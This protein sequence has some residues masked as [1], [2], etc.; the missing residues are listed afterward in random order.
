MSGLGLSLPA[1]GAGSAYFLI[2]QR[3][4]IASP[5]DQGWTK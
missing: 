3:M 4:S 2:R 1:W 5:S